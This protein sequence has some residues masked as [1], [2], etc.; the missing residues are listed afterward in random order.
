MLLICRSSLFSSPSRDVRPSAADDGQ[1]ICD[2]E[3]SV[4]ERELSPGRSADD[5]N[6]SHLV[7]LC[8]GN[9]CVGAVMSQTFF[10]DDGCRH[11]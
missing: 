9:M 4:L 5:L 10:H 3:I 7:P 1:L 6:R 8:C 11:P 2:S